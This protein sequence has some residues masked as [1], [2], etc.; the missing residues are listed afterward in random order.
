MSIPLLGFTLF[1]VLL[2]N[3]NFFTSSKM[4]VKKEPAQ[5][6]FA[7]I[8]DESKD[9]TLLNYDGLDMGEYTVANIIPT[10]YFFHTPNISRDRLPKLFEEQESAIKNKKVKY[11]VM[12]YFVGERDH[13][14]QPEEVIEKNKL[15]M[16]NYFI[17]NKV[18]E[19]STNLSNGDL[20]K[21][22]GT[23]YLFERRE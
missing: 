19:N 9:S 2:P 4:V 10:Q 11:I 17:R 23:Y 13:K 5:M 6:Q 8:I 22:V 14:P 18:K 16:N 21:S 1:L 12:N 15:L 7:K 20:L 3:S